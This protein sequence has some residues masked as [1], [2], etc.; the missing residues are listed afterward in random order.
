MRSLGKEL[1]CEKE[2]SPKDYPTMPTSLLRYSK[3]E[4]FIWNVDAVT[5]PYDLK[6]LPSKTKKKYNKRDESG[7]LYYLT[8]L[9]VP[10][11]DRSPERTYELMGILRTW[12][13]TKEKM[14]KEIAAGRVIQTKPGAI[15]RYKSYLDEQKGLALNNIWTDIP[16]INSQA[17][18]RMGYPTQKPHCSTG[19]YHKS[20]QQQKQSCP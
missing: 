19:P 18:E 4:K 11:H 10:G 7:R 2:E 17:K 12:R 14:E 5:I 6:N 15:P 8:P 1:H 16:H 3:T 20:Q 13:W 9:I